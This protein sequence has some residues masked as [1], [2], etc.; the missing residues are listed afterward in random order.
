MTEEQWPA[1]DL[2][3]DLTST[4]TR[5]AIATALVARDPIRAELVDDDETD[6]DD[7]T[8]ALPGLA[9]ALARAMTDR[10][11]TGIE[12]ITG[13]VIVEPAVQRAPPAVAK[14][15]LRAVAI[16]RHRRSTPPP[17]PPPDEEVVPIVRGEP[18]PSLDERPR[19][20]P[21][22]SEA[23]EA[24]RGPIPRFFS[25][26]ARRLRGRFTIAASFAMLVGGA[27]HIIHA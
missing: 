22:Q 2:I 3:A 16:E 5:E 7:P 1:Y 20:E 12:R 26:I 25:A 19:I 15:R 8:M 6:E 18:L 24:L 4:T 27:V 14:V 21:T 10:P 11:E 23:F 17:L 9:Q 13:E